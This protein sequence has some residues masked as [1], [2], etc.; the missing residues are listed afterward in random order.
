MFLAPNAVHSEPLSK[1]LIA[2]RAELAARYIQSVQLPTGLFEYEYDFLLGRFTDGDNLVRQAAAAFVLAEYANHSGDASAAGSVR[3]A[4]EALASWSL[5]YG[6]GSV[7]SATGELKDGSTGATAFALLA[8][9]QYLD[10]TGDNRFSGS[11]LAWLKGL[12]ELQLPSGG[13][14]QSVGDA[15]ESSY[16]NGEAW[17]ALAHFARLF[18]ADEA[19]RGMLARADSYLM[20]RYGREPDTQ[21]AHWGLMSASL[22]YRT[23]KESRFL[24]F[25]SNLSEAYITELRP[26]VVPDRNACSAVEG[27]AAAALALSQ[28]KRGD[29]VLF[30]KILERVEAQLSANLAL[31]IMPGQVRFSLGNE[32]YLEDP[33]IVDFTGAFLKGG[34]IPITRIDYTQH[35]LSALM[36]YAEQQLALDRRR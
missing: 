16:F 31:Q 14:S 7:V 2:A 24:K 9:L 13:F 15:T 5:S 36:R 3:L 21:F 35:C 18:P 1:E 11:R 30:K 22:R 23:T 6:G 32:R 12:Q 10:A 20:D 19:A 25:I 29:G 28:G 4:V 33:R 34:H 27:L 17:L 8:E 26:V